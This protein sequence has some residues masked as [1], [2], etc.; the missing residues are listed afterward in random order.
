MFTES[1]LHL[2]HRQVFLTLI[3]FL[4]RRKESE[5]AFTKLDLVDYFSLAD[6]TLS[7]LP[8]HVLQHLPHVKSLDLCR[9]KITKLT[10]DDFRDIQELE[11]LLVAD[12]S[13]SK[14]DKDAIPKALKHVHLGLNKLSTLNGALRE[15]DDL[16]WIFINANN[17]KTID[18]ELP[19]KAKRIS[20]IHAANN[21]LQNLPKD[22]K[23]MTS[24]D[25]LYF[26]GN[27]LKSLDELDIAYNNL[28]SLNGSLRSL[29]A[30]RY[31]NLTH[32]LMTEFSLQEIKGLKRLSVIDLSH[33]KINRGA[34]MGLHGLLRLNLSNNLLQQI[35]PDDLI[36]LEDLRLL[37]V[38]HNH[39]TTLEETSKTFLPSLEELIAHHNNITMLD[40]DFHGLPSLC[41]ADLS[42][43]KIQSVNYD[44]VSKSRCTINGVPSILKI[45]LQDNPVLCD[46]RLYELMTVLESLNA[47]VSGV[48]ACAAAHTASPVL[49]R[50]LN[51]ALP[52]AAPVV[53]LRAGEPVQPS[54]LLYRRVGAL[55]GHVLPEREGTLPILVEPPVTL[56]PTSSNVVVKWPDERRSEAN[57]HIAHPLADHL[58]LRDKN[59]SPR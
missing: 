16:E 26:Y 57:A 36:G 14:I 33:N 41:M 40:K 4:R 48:S 52:E 24:L 7:E 59:D 50:A 39:I 15:L 47:R 17:L 32:N 20:L 44:L 34:L 31:L 58:R 54:Q 29:K 8:R 49:M 30:L 12:N 10:V 42:F 25:S 55:I 1:K 11:H 37:D 38:S 3:M 43:N 5:S 51:D 27:K 2:R 13:I 45:Y 46:E 35:A 18:N 56:P 21:E 9:N 6:N 22:L 53:V 19:V 28:Q 23:Q